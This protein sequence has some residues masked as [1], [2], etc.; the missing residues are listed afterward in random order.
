[1]NNPMPLGD[2]FREHLL[3]PQNNDEDRSRRKTCGVQ[4]LLLMDDQPVGDMY[5][6]G[7]SVK[8]RLNFIHVPSYYSYIEI[9]LIVRF[10][11]GE[12]REIHQSTASSYIYKPRNGEMP[13]LTPIRGP[14][15]DNTPLEEGA[16]PPPSW[17]AAVD[18][19][20][21]ERLAAN[22]YWILA[23]PLTGW[24]TD[25]NLLTQPPITENDRVPS[26]GCQEDK[27][28]RIRSLFRGD[29][30]LRLLVKE[31]YMEPVYQ[32]IIETWHNE[33]DNPLA[34]FYEPHP[35][36]AFIQIGQYP[37]AV[38]RPQIELPNR[39]VFMNQADYITVLGY[40]LVGEAEYVKSIFD[41]IRETIGEIRVLTIP[42]AGDRR[43]WA[44]LQLDVQLASA[45]QPGDRLELSFNVD[46]HDP[47]TTWG[48]EV[49][50]QLFI[51]PPGMVPLIL[52]RRWD[53]GLGAWAQA[54]TPEF[55]TVTAEAN[56]RVN[57]LYCRL[58][59][60][61]P[62]PVKIKPIESDRTFRQEIHALQV[63]QGHD[64]TMPRPH[65]AVWPTILGGKREALEVYNVFSQLPLPL[66]FEAQWQRFTLDPAQREAANAL[67][68]VPGRIML[69]EGPAGTGKSTFCARVTTLFVE[70]NQTG[71]GRAKHQ[72]MFTT[73]S[74]DNVDHLFHLARRS[75]EAHVT[76]VDP[77]IIIR[78]HTWDTEMEYITHQA[79]RK[80]PQG[81]DA[82]PPYL[83]ADADP[84][85]LQGVERLLLEAYNTHVE[86]LSSQHGVPDRR[87]REL[88][89]SA[90]FHILRMVGLAEPPIPASNGENIWRIRQTLESLAEGD[91]VNEEQ[92]TTF[93]ESV[94]ELR[95]EL[96]AR[97]HIVVCTAAATSHTSLVENF[98]PRVIWVDE[99]AKMH[100]SSMWPILA[101]YRPEAWVLLGDSKQLKPLVLSTGDVN[102]FAPQRHLSLF[103]R[104]IHAGHPRQNFTQQQRMHPSISAVSNRLF[105][106]GKLTDGAGVLHNHDITQRLSEF[107]GTH[108]HQSHSHLMIK[109]TEGCSGRDNNS[110]STSNPT[111]LPV[112]GQLTL[113]LIVSQTI[114]PSDLLIL[115]PY[116][117][118]HRRLFQLLHKLCVA[119][120]ALGFEGVKVRKIDG[121]QG[122]KSPVVILNIPNT[123][124]AGFLADPGRVNVSITRA[125]YGQYIVLNADAIFHW[126]KKKHGKVLKSLLSAML[127]QQV[128]WESYLPDQRIAPHLLEDPGHDMML[129]AEDTRNEAIDEDTPYAANDEDIPDVAIEDTAPDNTWHNM[130]ERG[131][132]H[133]AEGVW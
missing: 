28:E 45:M 53:S 7:P 23:V 133:P 38:S 119:Y 121:F 18:S 108:F 8:I 83:S 51:V 129:S 72:T 40:G 39:L 90:A 77:L 52:S 27:I 128:T 4:A 49:T 2:V 30:P 54:D 3:D 71:L 65:P 102:C 73:A 6:K 34:P 110:Y 62:T 106:A 118:D 24:V 131:D 22:S 50:N 79:R 88:E 124:H 76:N 109:V 26:F 5:V 12:S 93:R 89:G 33:L 111:H 123:H 64:T 95:D 98:H 44:V 115:T 15:M 20:F 127:N 116:E 80:Q 117:A 81:P 61:D 92:M 36:Q 29:A 97:A 113:D 59:Q 10:T 132:D 130:P 17:L 56:D 101:Y 112:I 103:H 46:A 78:W 47:D 68:H 32:E 126:D 100:E 99:A 63:L 43:Y 58:L 104:L 125:Q 48:A 87:F 57:D 25:C 42:Y 70:S 82:G 91:P 37:D 69:I 96:L 94:K 67:M 16:I 11:S 31:L 84:A 14:A 114:A 75:C 85:H 1:M 21:H 19:K 122:A 74:N 35:N 13:V 60:L 66:D 41:H 9:T 107:N 105:Y 86:N 120:P 55:P